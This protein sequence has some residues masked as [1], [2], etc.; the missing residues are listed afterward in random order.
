MQTVS[1]VHFSFLLAS[2]V[3]PA[4]RRTLL[5]LC[6]PRDKALELAFDIIALLVSLSV[7]SGGR[8]I[9]TYVVV[10]DERTNASRTQLE[11]RKSV[12]RFICDI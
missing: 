11:R 6:Q 8:S 1:I 12:G 5:Q 10:F 7:G 3:G 4:L 9:E 2:A